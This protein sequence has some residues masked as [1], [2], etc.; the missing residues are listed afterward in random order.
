MRELRPLRLPLLVEARRQRESA[1]ID[2]ESP[3]STM[4]EHAMQKSTSSSSSEPQSPVSPT[5]SLR[6]QLRFSSSSSSLASSPTMHDSLDVFAPPKRPLTEVKEEPQE[7]EEDVVMGDIREETDYHSKS[8]GSSAQSLYTRRQVATTIPLTSRLGINYEEVLGMGSQ[9]IEDQTVLSPIDCDW[10]DTSLCYTDFDSIHLSKRRRP[11]ESVLDGMT[12]R[13]GTRFPSL[14]RKW[15]SRRD[16]KSASTTDTFP[17]ALATRSRAN[18]TRASSVIDSLVDSTERHD[19][20]VLP[21]PRRSLSNESV[22]DPPVSPIDIKKANA[23]FETDEEASAAIATTP[24]LP[25]V[26][27]QFPSGL[28]D[29]PVQS[30]LQSPKI[31]DS[32][33]VLDFPIFTPRVSGLPS[34]PL[35]TKPSVSS[36]H[37]RQLLPSGDIPPMLLVDP[38]DEWSN[39]LGHANF[40]IY[41]EPYVPEDFA[42]STCRQFR[43]DWDAAR[44]NYVKHLARTGEHY[45]ITSKIHQLTEEKWAQVNAIWK[46]N[47]D[48]VLSH[49][50]TSG[51]DGAQLSKQSSVQQ[52]SASPMKIP[53][54]NGPRSEGKFPKV[55]DEGIVGPMVQEKPLP[56]PRP[57]RKRAFWKFLQ[58]VLPGA[59][60][61]GRG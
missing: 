48:V 26:M 22:N 10:V 36:F 34:P 13:F 59:V 50:T 40:T 32:P 49:T 5:F 31:V 54:T 41:P 39:K 17:E 4:S 44:C 56:Q 37:R 45:S 19:L 18:S 9:P 30:P 29:E 57:S 11:D 3:D 47:N 6:G 60:A 58:G 7:R 42:L 53:P 51:D 12:S 35:S 55:G 15:K 33:S 25:P 46:R 27:A 28:S 38:Q 8:E 61:F 52:E 43:A 14:S 16:G 20:H 24:L 21:T 2:T 1:N 23:H